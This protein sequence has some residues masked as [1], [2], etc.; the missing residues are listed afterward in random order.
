[1][2]KASKTNKLPAFIFS[3]FILSLAIP[4]NPLWTVAEKSLS[5]Q[6]AL[7]N[8][9]SLTRQFA[10]LGL[11]AFAVASLLRKKIRPLHINGYLGGFIV[12]YL[13]WAVLSV[14]WAD[15]IY[16]TLKRVTALIFISLGILAISM[17]LSFQEIAIF[18]FYGCGITLLLGLISE[19]ALNTFQPFNAEYRF[20]GVIH[21]NAQG[22]NCAVLFALSM[23][24]ACTIKSRALL[25]RIAGIIAFLFLLLTKSRVAAMSGILAV[26][27]G[28]L[29]LYP[30]TLKKI[31]IY[32]YIFILGLFLSYVFIGDGIFSAL[33]Y[34]AHNVVTLGRRQDEASW[35][36]A[37][38]KITWAEDLKFVF[39]RPMEGYGYGGFWTPA[40]IV[41]ITSEVGR[42]LIA[43]AHSGYIDT[44]LSIGIIGTILYI[45]ILLISMRKSIALY[46][47]SGKN[48]YL[49]FVF[50]LIFWLFYNSIFESISIQPNIH[51]FIVYAL[52][53][54]L[55]FT[56]NT[57]S[58]MKRLAY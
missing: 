44:L 51:I 12:F 5:Q 55:A 49:I 10:L 54:K 50:I 47:N 16:I 18:A 35:T 15:D 2:I 7:V 17:L 30:R 48:P 9:G 1:M 56:S 37:D 38:R 23:A 53:A 26:I 45:I 46:R 25:Y 27:V 8:E 31:T 22:Q 40:H 4:L 13:L 19:I 29:L 3:F 57:S 6:I 41:S 33:K 43:S 34:H 28:L 24:L 58:N 32:I 21:A 52:I 42:G 36:F 20:S 11:G 14:F 39:Q